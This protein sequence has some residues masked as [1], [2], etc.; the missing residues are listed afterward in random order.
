V[1]GTDN[2]PLFDGSFGQVSAG[3]RASVVQNIDVSAVEENGQ[4][5]SP[6]R[7]EFALTFGQFVN[8]A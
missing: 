3:V 7:D 5:E 6:D 2:A 1:P 8:P 4:R